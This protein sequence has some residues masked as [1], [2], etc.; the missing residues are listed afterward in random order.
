[1]QQPYFKQDIAK[2]KQLLAEAGYPN[3]FKAKLKNTPTYSFLGNAGIAVQDQLK[4]VGIEFEIISLE[5]SVFLNDYLVKKDY[6]AFVSGFSA[7]VDP[8]TALDTYVTGRQNN[9]LNYSNP[10]YDELIAKGAATS[11]QAERAKI[12]REAQTIFTEDAAMIMLYAANEYEAMQSYVKG[13][14][15]YLNGSHVSLR[16]AWLDKAQ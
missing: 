15:H 12:Y 10:K 5:W 4:A 13:Y 16:E 2:A 1:M 6:E 11:D 3:G 8:H 14:V 9:F 7:F